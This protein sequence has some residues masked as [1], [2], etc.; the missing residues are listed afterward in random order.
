LKEFGTLKS[1]TLKFQTLKFQ[2]ILQAVEHHDEKSYTES[3]GSTQEGISELLDI[4]SAADDLDALGAIGVY[5]YAEIY[6]F[7][8]IPITDLPGRVLTNLE[9]RMTK[10]NH[11]FK[12][13]PDFMKGHMKRHALIRDF[14]ERLKGDIL[15]GG[16]GQT[17]ELMDLISFS[18]ENKINLMN[19]DIKMAD[20]S[21]GLRSFMEQLHSET[22]R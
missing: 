9:A 1:G 3:I 22:G 18:L 6:L 16:R 12:D 2:T 14:Y 15:N 5:R 7:R 8:G 20:L 19:P 4:L 21:P 10:L 11:V 13:L 17:R